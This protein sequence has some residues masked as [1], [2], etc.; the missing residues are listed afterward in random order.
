MGYGVIERWGVTKVA[1]LPDGKSIVSSGHPMNPAGEPQ[2]SMVS[3]DGTLALWDAETLDPIGN[4]ST[5]WDFVA[6]QRHENCCYNW[7]GFAGAGCKTF[8]DEDSC[9]N[10]GMC[11]WGACVNA[12]AKPWEDGTG[13]G[14]GSIWALAV[15]PDGAFIAAGGVTDAIRIWDAGLAPHRPLNPCFPI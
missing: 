8:Y 14:L 4:L 5:M 1:F 15:S 11:E 6:L 12:F 10:N 7:A 13:G 2:G 3:N 9:Q